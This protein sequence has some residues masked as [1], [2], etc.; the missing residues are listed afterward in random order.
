MPSDAVV[1][2][3]A[4]AFVGANVVQGCDQP[5]G[6]TQLV[7]SGSGYPMGAWWRL[8]QTG[9]PGTVFTW[10]CGSGLPNWA[11]AM[12]VYSGNPT[13]GSPVA[14]YGY[15]SQPNTLVSTID[16]KSETADTSADLLLCAFF[17]WDDSTASLTLSVPSGMTDVTQLSTGASDTYPSL[18]IASLNP[19]G[20]G[21]TGTQ[22]TNTSSGT[23]LLEAI[24]VVLT[25]AGAPLAPTITYPTSGQYLDVS[26]GLTVSWGYNGNGAPQT[27][28]QLKLDTKYWTGSAWTSTNTW[29]TS[30]ATSVSL[31]SGTP[32]TN[33]SSHTLTV[34]TEAVPGQGT[35]SSLSFTG[36]APPTVT[37]STPTGSHTSP[38]PAINWTGTFPSSA[39][40][41][42]GYRAIVY[43][44]A[45]YGAGGFVPGFGPSYYDSGTV[46]GTATS[47]TPTG[48][49]ATGTFRAYVCLTDAHQTGPFNYSGFT[50]SVTVPS[51]PTLTAAWTQ[52]TASTLLT[53]TGAT[54]Y[55]SQPTYASFY[56]SD[57]GGT[58]WNLVRGGSNVSLSTGTA[59]L[60]DYE[61]PAQGTR[62]YQ[63]YV[64]ALVS[65]SVL[66]SPASSTQSTTASL[67]NWWLKNPLNSAQNIT[68]EVS[69]DFTTDRLEQSTVIYPL[70]QTRPS[71]IFDVIT[72]TDGG[73]T[74][75]TT[76]T[77]AY[78]A[79]ETILGAQAVL[80]V[81]NPFGGNWYV[82]LAITTSSASTAQESGTLSASSA[83]SPFRTTVLSWVEV[84]LQAVPITS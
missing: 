84:G 17:G 62:Q 38:N 70:G 13:T 83:A 60:T 37:V 29:V 79:L 15:R 78:T 35:S 6:W 20:P 23:S 39:P 44:S 59:T 5:S 53:A 74:V 54:S 52:S 58:T 65:G 73:A 77:A 14:S 49:P 8:V 47:Q 82:R 25:V 30:S 56:S 57:N 75:T 67:G 61:G 66:T 72:G 4:V 43:S 63:A 27:G 21:A 80:L 45:Q 28:Y 51:A 18:T 41:Q 2:D 12:V 55:D 11:G 46:S 81:Q 42:T 68:V 71:V 7:D 24:T 19:V 69:A 36:E 3:V 10:T 48:V 9:D 40:T 50:M 76:T 22:T 33:G 32:L 1:G 16:A 26:S 64:N 31:P 34:N